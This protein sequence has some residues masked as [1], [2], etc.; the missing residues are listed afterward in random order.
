[1]ELK[2]M[3]YEKNNEAVEFYAFEKKIQE[4]L[5]VEK[6]NHLELEEWMTEKNAGALEMLEPYT[7]Q[8]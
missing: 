2:T 8:N 5:V 1:M 6:K 3:A 7:L 4:Y